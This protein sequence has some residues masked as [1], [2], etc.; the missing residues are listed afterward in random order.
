MS[1]GQCEPGLVNL[2]AMIFDCHGS[3]LFFL[4]TLGVAA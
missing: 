2:V 4:N 3:L 1:L